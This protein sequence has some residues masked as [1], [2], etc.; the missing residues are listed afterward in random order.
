MVARQTG[1]F[2]ITVEKMNAP[3]LVKVWPSHKMGSQLDEV[4]VKSWDG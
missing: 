2:V 3:E 1:V 4:T